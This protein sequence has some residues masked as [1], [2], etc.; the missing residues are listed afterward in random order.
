MTKQEIEEIKTEAN[1]MLD[2]KKKHSVEDEAKKWARVEIRVPWFDEANPNRELVL[3]EKNTNINAMVDP[4][5]SPPLFKLADTS[6]LQIWVH[7]P[8]EYLPLIR[9]GL[10]RN[11]SGRLQWDIRFQSE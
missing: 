4:I 2:Q 7:P 6:R 9:E 1:T 10:K 8:E 3:V 5:N 11:G